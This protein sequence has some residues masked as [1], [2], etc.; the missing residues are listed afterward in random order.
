MIFSRFSMIYQSKSHLIPLVQALLRA[1][2]GACAPLRDCVLPCAGARASQVAISR[3]S[4]CGWRTTREARV[5]PSHE[6]DRSAE[7]DLPRSICIC[8][9]PIPSLP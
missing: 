9:Q 4:G 8:D 2:A 5:R 6:G 1:G 3:T 7:R